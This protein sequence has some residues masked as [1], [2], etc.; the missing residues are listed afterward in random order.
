MN[1][2]QAVIENFAEGILITSEEAKILYINK[3]LKE[4][5]DQEQ[6]F[7]GFLKE[8]GLLNDQG[9]SKQIFKKYKN[10]VCGS[11]L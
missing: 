2:Y 8:S 7:G 6:K 11:N 1:D 3:Q 5:I 9:L 10:P 4:F